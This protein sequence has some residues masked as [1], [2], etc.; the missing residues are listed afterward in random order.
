MNTRP[1]SIMVAPIQA[2]MP[3]CVRNVSRIVDF[4]VP[5]DATTEVTQEE[6]YEIY[7]EL[8]RDRNET[9]LASENYG[10]IQL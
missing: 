3:D 10:Y 9:N 5:Q 7:Q 4:V 8:A 6:K 1:H 2:R